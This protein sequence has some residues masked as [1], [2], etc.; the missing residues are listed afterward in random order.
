MKMKSLL[1]IAVLALSIV[2]GPAARAETITFPCGGG[3]TYSV[4]MPQGVLLEGK[5]CIGSLT[6]DSSVKIIDKE[7]FLGAK[8]TNVIFP[9]SVTKIEQSAFFLTEITNLDLPDTV[10]ELGVLAFGR[11]P[12]K[13]VKLPKTLVK[14]ADGLFVGTKLEKIEIP[15]SVTSIGTNAFAETEL[16]DIQI[17]ESVTQIYSKTFGGN[18][19][20]VSVSLPDSLLGIWGD[21]FD[22]NYALTKIS[23]CGAAK[24]PTLII[25]T[26]C[27][28]ERKAVIDAKLAADKA[29]ADKA[30]S[31][32]RI[33]AAKSKYSELSLEIDRMIKK[34]PSKKSEI[35]LYKKKISLFERIDQ[36]NIPTVELNLAG[37]ETK[38]VMM[39]SVYGKIAR[40]ITCTKGKLTKKVTDVTPKCPA[41]YKKK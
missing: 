6:I 4:L 8:V 7:A 29:A 40:T 39:K 23:Y 9:S 38:L 25:P 37:I 33:N 10:M 26:S 16:T 31:E 5:K 32:A 30:A 21:A 11:T 3:A 1:A 41:G 19:K 15:N 36:A 27:P 35:E 14:I 28:P 34:Y 2:S 13:T 12:I 24:L 22:R 20:L 18:L 17:P